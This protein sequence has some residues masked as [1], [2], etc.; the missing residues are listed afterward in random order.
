MTVINRVPEL[1][2]Q[3]FGG[4]DKI[5]IQQVA[6]DVGLTYATTHGWIKNQVQRADF[7]VLNKWCKYLGVGIGDILEYVPDEEG[8]SGGR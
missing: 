2:A 7:P 8:K 3:K 5:V 4:E 1:V 6:N